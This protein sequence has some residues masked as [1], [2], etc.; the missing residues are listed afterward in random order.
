MW[1]KANYHVMSH[2]SK[3]GVYLFAQEYQVLSDGTA[4]NERL[5]N[6]NDHDEI[7]KSLIE[8]E[9]MLRLVKC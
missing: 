5:P 3:L 6:V 7:R 8:V 4:L 2:G 9:R 1:A